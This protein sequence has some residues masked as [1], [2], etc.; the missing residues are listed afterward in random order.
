MKD[1]AGLGPF[2]A[3]LFDL[4]GKVAL[5][6]GAGRGLGREM[7]RAL[8]SAGAFTWVAGRDQAALSG[9]VKV[10][11]QE[12]GKAVAL[13]FDIDNEAACAGAIDSIVSRNGR[14]DILVNNAG[15]RQ[16]TGF[17]G[18]TRERFAAMLQTN[19]IAQT[20]LAQK[21]AAVMISRAE[22]GR[23]INISSVAALRG[24]VLDPSYVA[25]KAALSGMT[26]ALAN[27][28]GRHGI[29]VNE[30]APGPFATEFNMG[31]VNDPKMGQ[32]VTKGTIM[33]RWGQ[34]DELCSAVLFLAAPNA[35]F[36]TGQ[37]IVIDGGYTNK[38]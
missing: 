35:G 36:I 17:A 32:N 29:T 31:L 30:I 13:A 10:I 19:L 16:R 6:T 8:A 33:G 23:I 11:E 22:G 28:N 20:D 21:A 14:L 7:A 4:S 25:A 1:E 38:A 15:I 37:Q 5:V 9:T 3:S 34:P 12:G 2:A 18:L 24:N 27:E 26:R